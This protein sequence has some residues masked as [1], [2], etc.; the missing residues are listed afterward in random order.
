M[1]RRYKLQSSF[2][3]LWFHF[4][5]PIRYYISVARLGLAKTS[6]SL[7][8]QRQYPPLE[9]RVLSILSV[10]YLSNLLTASSRLIPCPYGTVCRSI[11][12][13]L[14]SARAPDV[15]IKRF[16]VDVHNDG[17]HYWFPF[18]FLVAAKAGVA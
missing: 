16:L 9:F 6:Q 17:L 2:H 10:K 8:L 18:P 1:S 7:A 14:A 4:V 5:Q 3:L 13:G 15:D 11:H 12:L